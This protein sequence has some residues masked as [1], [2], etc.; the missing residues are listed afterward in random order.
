MISEVESLETSYFDYPFLNKVLVR[1]RSGWSWVQGA[2]G[3]KGM[4]TSEHFKFEFVK[5]FFDHFPMLSWE[6]LM[7]RVLHGKELIKDQVEF[8]TGW[9][10]QVVTRL[11]EKGNLQEFWK[12]LTVFP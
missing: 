1:W 2:H 9:Q 7:R 10:S 8:T 11:H 12:K 4:D 6:H 5:L 3:I